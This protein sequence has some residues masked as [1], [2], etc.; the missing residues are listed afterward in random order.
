MSLCCSEA[1][2]SPD[3]IPSRELVGLPRLSA[4]LSHLPTPPRPRPRPAP[5]SSIWCWRLRHPT[6]VAVVRKAEPHVIS[7]FEIE[8]DQR[9]QRSKEEVTRGST[10]HIFKKYV[11]HVGIAREGFRPDALFQWWHTCAACRS[12]LTR[13]W[14]SRE[15]VGATRH[16]PVDASVLQSTISFEFQVTS[17]HAVLVTWVREKRSNFVARGHRGPPSRKSTSSLGNRSGRS[18]RSPSCREA[19]VHPKGGGRLSEAFGHLRTP[20]E[21]FGPQCAPRGWH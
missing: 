5:P 21:A 19:E 12:E 8:N 11:C 10:T 18:E 1:S 14:T 15:Q 20:S 6:R 17:G 7:P 13:R 3:S 4:R 2:I 9:Y 16:W